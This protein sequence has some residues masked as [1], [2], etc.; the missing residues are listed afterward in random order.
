ML[1]EFDPA[2]TYKPTWSQPGIETL[3]ISSLVIKHIIDDPLLRRVSVLFFEAPCPLMV[4]Q[5]EQYQDNS[6]WTMESVES[7]VKQIIA[8]LDQ[9]QFLK[10][11]YQP[12]SERLRQENAAR[13]S[14]ISSIKSSRLEKSPTVLEQA[15]SLAVSTA[16]WLKDG[17]AIV[18]EETLKQRLD[19]C[20]ACE[21]WDSQSFVGTGKCK[22]CGCSTQAKLRM[23]SE[24][25]PISRW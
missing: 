24:K 8:E 16:K 25:C 14:A 21:F 9:E 18:S 23:S 12:D 13:I 7:R 3:V 5:A 17:A 4:W 15:K 20:K 6:N 10:K 1:F 2:L 19:A 22:K 11:I